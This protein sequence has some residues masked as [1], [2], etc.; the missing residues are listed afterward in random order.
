LLTEEDGFE[1]EDDG[2]EE[3][4]EEEINGDKCSFGFDF[5]EK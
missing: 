1:D 4:M 2:E 5:L 3:I